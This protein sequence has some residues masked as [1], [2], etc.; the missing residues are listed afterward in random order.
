MSYCAAPPA[1]GGKFSVFSAH[2][3]APKSP[4]K[5]LFGRIFRAA[6]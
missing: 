3:R 1:K 6:K 4:A 5:V 2:P